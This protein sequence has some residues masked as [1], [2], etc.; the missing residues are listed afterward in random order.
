MCDSYVNLICSV[1][2]IFQMYNIPLIARLTLIFVRR[3]RMISRLIIKV[4]IIKLVN[5]ALGE[6]A[7][8]ICIISLNL[9]HALRGIKDNNT[10]NF[11]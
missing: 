9:F 5:F 8:L 3:S 2:V 1:K 4:E 11:Q 6:E 7:F 10:I